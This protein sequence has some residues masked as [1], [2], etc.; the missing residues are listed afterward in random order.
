MKIRNAARG[1]DVHTPPCFT[2]KLHPHARAGISTGSGSH[3]S[4]N[5]TLR[6]WQLPSITMRAYGRPPRWRAKN[7]STWA[8][9]SF[10]ATG[11]PPVVAPRPPAACALLRV[12]T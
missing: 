10:H 6:Q 12:A 4:E 3:A 2:Q 9:L 8:M 5:R 1:F 7:A 11:L